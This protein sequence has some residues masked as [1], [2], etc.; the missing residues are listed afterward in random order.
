MEK[1]YIRWN[2]RKFE[3]WKTKILGYTQLRKLKDI[4]VWQNNNVNADKNETASLEVIHLLD[5]RSISLVIREVKDD[6][7]KAFKILRERVKTLY[8]QLT[9]LQK[10][11]TENI[12]T[13][14][15][16]KAENSNSLILF[17]MTLG[18]VKD[19]PKCP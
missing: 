5:D 13:D 9:T 3:I 7:R 6:G 14:Y 17:K 1:S 11:T 19:S 4:L 10:G 15:L 2:E 8:N 12:T 18:H 16:M